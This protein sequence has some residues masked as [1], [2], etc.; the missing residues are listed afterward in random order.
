MGT[1]GSRLAAALAAT[2]ALCAPGCGG[3]GD[4]PQDRAL[5]AE[6]GAG[7]DALTDFVDTMV[8]LSR[9]E[10]FSDAELDAATTAAM[11]GTAYALSQPEA[12]RLRAAIGR[13][14]RRLLRVVRGFTELQ[15]DLGDLLVD[16]ARHR[17]A[18][19]GAQSLLVA[20][21]EYVSVAA[22]ALVDIRGAID[23]LRFTYVGLEQLWEAARSGDVA[24]VEQLRDRYE[25]ETLEAVEA[26]ERTAV[27]PGA[28]RRLLARMAADPDARAVLEAINEAH[29]E[30]VLAHLEG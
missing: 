19:E 16:P 1:R 20:W 13:G 21:N 4:T 26:I 24:R 23:R 27:D 18:S 30:G 17:E 15:H 22:G 25:T 10:Q 29:P 14:D 9:P 3:T 8:E 12:R 28:E 6:I 7:S 5:I 2:L 11:D